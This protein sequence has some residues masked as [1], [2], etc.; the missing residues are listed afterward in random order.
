MGFLRGGRKG[1]REEGREGG[2]E[3]GRERGRE[4]GREG[5]RVGVEWSGGSGMEIH[6]KDTSRSICK[7]ALYTTCYL[8]I[9]TFHA[10][11]ATITHT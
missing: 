5:G 9:G 11:S 3:G 8:K 1:G 6:C 4:G 7:R 2:R 10:N